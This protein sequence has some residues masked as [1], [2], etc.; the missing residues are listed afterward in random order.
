MLY[1]NI[2]YVLGYDCFRPDW[3]NLQLLAEW[4]AFPGI[5]GDQLEESHQFFGTILRGWS[6]GFRR[7]TI[8]IA[9][10]REML[11]SGTNYV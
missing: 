5:M 6:R 1:I 9:C 4:L 7:P 3:E 8:T 10:G 2:Y 11:V